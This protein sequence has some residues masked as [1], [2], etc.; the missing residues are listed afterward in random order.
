[1]KFEIRKD[2]E[3]GGYYPTLKYENYYNGFWTEIADYLEI[4]R[5]NYVDYMKKYGAY[6]IILLRKI[7]PYY[8]LFETYKECQKFID[9]EELMPYLVMKELTK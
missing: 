1:M 6:S 8:Y 4:P 9:S 7:V 5:E 3:K 2:T